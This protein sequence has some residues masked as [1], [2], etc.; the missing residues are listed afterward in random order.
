MTIFVNPWVLFIWVIASWIIGMLGR[1]TRFGFVGN[2]LVAFLF[3]P[4]VGVI[5]LLASDRWAG[6]G[7]RRRDPRRR[8]GGA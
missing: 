8:S 7:G 5:V 1:D 3:S 4:V 6:L 2:F